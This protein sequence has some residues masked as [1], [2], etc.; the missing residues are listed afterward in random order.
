MWKKMGDADMFEMF[1]RSKEKSVRTLWYNEWVPYKHAEKLAIT[2]G[3]P[4]TLQGSTLKDIK[5]ITQILQ[6]LQLRQQ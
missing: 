2:C 6:S 3:I 1:D 5:I 4:N